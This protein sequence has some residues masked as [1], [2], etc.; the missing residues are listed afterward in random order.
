MLD[1]IWEE[2]DEG[3]MPLGIYTFMHSRADLS[4]VDRKIL[5]QWTHSLQDTLQP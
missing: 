4:E 2:V 3:E 1:E 5:Y